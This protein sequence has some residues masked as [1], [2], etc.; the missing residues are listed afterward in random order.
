MLV[1]V[2]QFFNPHQL[3]RSISSTIPSGVLTQIYLDVEIEVEGE[4][5]FSIWMRED[6]VNVDSIYVVKSGSDGP[7]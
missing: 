1:R 7:N 4:Y 3:F 6:G 5:Q 2:W